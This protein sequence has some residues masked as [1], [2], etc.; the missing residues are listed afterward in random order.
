MNTIA[1]GAGAKP[2]ATVV[3]SDVVIISS[4]IARSWPMS[5][6]ITATATKRPRT[7]WRNSL[8][9][10]GFSQSS[11]RFMNH[12]PCPLA[13]SRGCAVAQRDAVAR[14]LG[15]AVARREKRTRFCRATARPRNCATAKDRNRASLHASRGDVH[16]HLLE[17]D[18][19]LM[20][21]GDAESAS[22]KLGQQVAR[23]FFRSRELD[24]HRVIVRLRLHDSGQFQHCALQ[25][26]GAADRANDQRPLLAMDREHFA[27]RARAQD[28]SALDDHG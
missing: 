8:T 21:P 9:A 26:L 16:E 12:L 1:P 10:I 22:H 28:S 24:L 11:M 20:E 4:A 5:E 23:A 3:R 7:A 14:L 13:R 27:E 25:F 17:I 6:R 19:S 18:A 15:R 2:A